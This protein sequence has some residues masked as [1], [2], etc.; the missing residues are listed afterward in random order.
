MLQGAVN[1][2][3]VGLAFRE[4]SSGKLAIFPYSQQ[5]FTGFY[6]Y[7]SPTVF[8]AAPIGNITPL[9]LPSAFCFR[10]ADNGTNRIASISYDGITFQT[11]YSVSRTTFI[12]ADQ[13]G[14][15][16]NSVN[17]TGAVTITLLSWVEA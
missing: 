6:N 10:I 1:N 8:S 5:R 7:T 16:V 9:V 13:V 11:I 12:T 15:Y 17:G 14:F 2:D 4:S 3:H